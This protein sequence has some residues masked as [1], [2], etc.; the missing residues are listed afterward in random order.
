M[1]S[2]C[3]GTAVALRSSNKR[4]FFYYYCPGNG[5]NIASRSFWSFVKIDFW[6]VK[7]ATI[8]V[9]SKRSVKSHFEHFPVFRVSLPQKLNY[10][11]NQAVAIPKV[12]NMSD[13]R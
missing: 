6:F 11:K 9:N 5:L 4:A 1:A 2:R 13:P 8:I 10:H 3:K 12:A 7:S